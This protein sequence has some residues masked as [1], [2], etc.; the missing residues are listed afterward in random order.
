M[1]SYTKINFSS[2]KIYTLELGM[3]VHIIIPAFVEAEAGGLQS[4]LRDLVT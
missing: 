4:D 1:R 2:S 3:A